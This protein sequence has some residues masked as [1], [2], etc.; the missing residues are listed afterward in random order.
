MPPDE[1][2]TTTPAETGESPPQ[3]P[4]PPAAP[5]ASDAAAFPETFTNPADLPP[6]L[7]TIYG[8][9][10][11][12]YEKIVAKARGVTEKA[13][14]VDR[15]Y[16][17]PQFA[18]ETVQ[19]WAAQQGFAL[20]KREAAAA[21][22]EAMRGTQPPATR[23]ARVPDELVEAI[24]AE[25][26]PEL[27][28]LARPLAASNWKAHQATMGPVL[29][30]RERE[31]RDSRTQEYETLAEELSEA[32]P[33]WEEHEEDMAAILDFLT[34]KALRHKRWGS[35]LALL[36]TLATGQGTAVR[37]ATRRMGEAARSRTTTGQSGRTMAPNV[38][39]RVLKARSTGDA[40]QIAVEHAREQ[41][42]QA[43]ATVPD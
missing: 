33:G 14:L 17:D 4:A 9:M 13:A 27:Q 29:E 1:D 11:K 18:T 30:T 38:T 12:S 19:Q 15:F 5:P 24:A 40:L 37:E 25:L 2:L 20:T 26:P 3:A 36:H 10:H 28:W 6:E 42:R 34:S 39:E 16:S 31:A 41:L 35:K 7:R 32:A 8:K 23:G 43:G 22:T 21:A